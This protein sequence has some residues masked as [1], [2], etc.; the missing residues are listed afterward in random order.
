MLV[1][2]LNWARERHRV[3]PADSL[4]WKSVI[5]SRHPKGAN[6]D[7]LDVRCKNNVFLVW[8]FDSDI[9]NFLQFLQLKVMP[10][11]FLIGLEV[12]G[13]GTCNDYVHINK[14]VQRKAYM[15]MSVI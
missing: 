9:F 4:Q 2:E 11:G 10:H 14:A 5:F 6:L 1:S 15:Q 13:Q 7:F 12:L 8:D 3:A